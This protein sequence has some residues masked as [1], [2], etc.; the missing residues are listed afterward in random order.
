MLSQSNLTDFSP[1]FEPLC[2]TVP[3]HISI[4]YSDT[5]D[6]SQ[7]CELTVVVL[8]QAVFI[9]DQSVAQTRRFKQK[10][11]GWILLLLWFRV[12]WWRR[13]AGSR[14]EELGEQNT[15]ARAWQSREIKSQD[16]K[17][18]QGW[19]KQGT[20]RQE[21]QGGSDTTERQKQNAH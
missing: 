4:H 14:A 17:P 15:N 11:R 7:C 9:L 13:A 10:M 6:Y 3:V 1:N 12:Q 2:E 5:L 20:S 16:R 8:F 21:T 19:S 18:R